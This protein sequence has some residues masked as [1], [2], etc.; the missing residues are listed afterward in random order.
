MLQ[1]AKNSKNVIETVYIF[2]VPFYLNM[3]LFSSRATLEHIKDAPQGLIVTYD[4]VTSKPA[5]PIPHIQSQTYHF[6][7]LKAKASIR[8]VSGT[9]H[10]ILNVHEALK[11][12]NPDL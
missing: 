4:I 9:V 7:H 1:V 11:G 12:S 5:L 6:F 8:Y 10:A 2:S 3:F